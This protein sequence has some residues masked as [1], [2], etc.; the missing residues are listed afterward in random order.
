[1]SSPSYIIVGSGVFG[2]STALYLI[3]KHPDAKITLIDRDNFNAPFRVAASWDWNKVIRADYS[4]IAYTKLGLE[5]QHLW[6]VDPIWQP[7]Y[8]ESGAAWISPT[9]FAEKVL[10]NFA[11]LGVKADIQG[12]SVEEARKLYDGLF[13]DADYT[14]VKQVLV[15]RTSGWAEAKEALQNTIKTAVGLGVTYVTAEVTAVELK[16]HRCCGVKTANGE[17]INA[18]RVILSTGAFTPK[19]LMNSA[20]EW[21]ELHASG[22]IIA[23]AVTEAIGPL[24]D[25]QSSILDTMP[26]II[27]DNPMENGAHGLK[28]SVVNKLNIRVGCDL[29]CLPLPSINAFKY[30]GQI[31][32]R[33]TLD[34]PITRTPLS[35][36][37]LQPN[38]AQWDVPLELKD[39]VRRGPESMFGRKHF[40]QELEKFRICWLVLPLR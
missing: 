6:R 23:A 16:E 11:E 31:I 30:W 35:M 18:D 38:Y 9:S 25:Q 14:G 3:R 32:F 5:A 40:N 24:T 22:R 7:F 39:D 8:H 2:A 26:V 12:Y 29:G 37:P 15:N 1:M 4:D 33:H 19:L 28:F 21:T 10:K 20:P 34:H 13:E 27:N 17:T 36:P